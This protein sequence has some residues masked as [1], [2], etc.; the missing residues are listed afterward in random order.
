MLSVV[1]KN[2]PENTQAQLNA[3]TA[4]LAELAGFP[5]QVDAA[6]QLWK[7]K[8]PANLFQT[9]KN[10]LSAMCVGNQRCMYCEDS[11]A[12]EI[13]HRRPKSLYP[14]A[15]TTGKAWCAAGDPPSNITATALPTIY[16]TRLIKPRCSASPSS[17]IPIAPS[18]RK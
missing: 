9:L 12:N 11:E 16:G 5:S 1:A 15:S 14:C 13:E 6:K 4:Q 8:A 17:I 18:G 7:S 10:T 2:L 3:H